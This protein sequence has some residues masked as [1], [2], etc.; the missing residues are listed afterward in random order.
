MSRAW[1]I[2][3]PMGSRSRCE[4]TH[5]IQGTILEI[6]R[7]E[8]SAGEERSAMVDPDPPGRYPM[9]LVIGQGLRAI[10]ALNTVQ[11]WVGLMDMSAVLKYRVHDIT[12]RYR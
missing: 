11:E 2:T 10:A 7:L 8:Q 5:I 1:L 12:H 3:G 4:K 6:L 9:A